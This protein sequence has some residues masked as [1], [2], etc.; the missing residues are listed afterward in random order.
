MLQSR[1]A[2]RLRRAVLILCAAILV[3]A[4][5]GAALAH[6]LGNFT[7]NHF[8]QITVGADRVSIH[9]VLDMAE[10]PTFQEKQVIDVDGDGL[11]STAELNTYLARVTPQYAREYWWISTVGAS[12]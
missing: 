3:S 6:P 8:A 11:T 10:I 1:A 9:Y 2:S 7:V 12:R 5:A 4:M